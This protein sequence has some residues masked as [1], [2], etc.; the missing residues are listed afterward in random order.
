MPYIGVSPQFGVRRKHTYTATAGQTSFSGA[1]SEGATLSYTDSNF[2][3]VYQNGVKLGDADYTSTSGTAIVLA[4]GASVD[5][6]VEIIVFDAFSAADTVSK[7]DGGTFDGNVTMAGT[8][9]VTGASTVTGGVSGDTTFT[10]SITGTT[11]TF[12]TADN[13]AQLTLVS[14]DADASR[15]A[16]LAIN[17]NSAS[18]ADNDIAGTI[19]FNAKN[20]A[21]E[22]IELFEINTTLIDASDGT[23]DSK[24]TI[25]GII[26]GASTNRVNLT[27]TETVFN[28][29]GADL[30]FRV[31]GDTNTHA[32]F[33]Q[34]GSNGVGIN[35]DSPNSF[36]QYADNLVVGTTSGENGITIATGS[37][38][39]ARFVFSDNT[40]SSAAA[41]VGAMEYAHSADFF[42]FY[43]GGNQRVVI[44]SD[45][46]ITNS[47]GSYGTI[48]DENLKENISDA[49]SQWDD[50]KALQVRK[51]S[52]KEDNLDSANK[53]GVIAQELEKSGMN[54]LVSETPLADPD[55]ITK[56]E[57]V[58]SV[59]YSILYMKAIK[60]L[61][62][63]MARIE[64]LEAKVTAL[65]SK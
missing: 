36:N 51:Y 21:A 55:D 43:C 26:G 9:G 64:T 1:G 61:Q 27:N 17:R 56:K 28:D 7:A 38:N 37:S 45:G 6:L 41:F 15:G 16:I 63:A 23:E 24:M 46:D 8:L 59:K 60:A 47:T 25:N 57:T 62:E 34:A 65:E 32:L 54:G 14:T 48:S 11:A 22:D 35:C 3:D 13:N 39:S 31:E 58:K 42:S 40:S 20:D 19:K 33:V 53:I 2:V 18:P 44:A 5:D 49:S 12:S 30:D 50:I 10:G 4:Q 29:D 52:M